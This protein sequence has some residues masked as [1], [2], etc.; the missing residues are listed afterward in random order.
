MS[1]PQLRESDSP[2]SSQLANT[3]LLE[4]VLQSIQKQLAFMSSFKDIEFNQ[5]AKNKYRRNQPEK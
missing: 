1:Q 4:L 5:S 2:S 3:K